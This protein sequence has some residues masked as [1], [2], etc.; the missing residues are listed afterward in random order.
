MRSLNEMFSMEEVDLMAAYEKAFDVPQ[1]E[2]ITDWWGDL[3]VYEFKLNVKP[4]QAEERLKKSLAA[5]NMSREEYAK[6]PYATHKALVE[7][8][9]ENTNP[10]F[11]LVVIF[12]KPVLFTCERLNRNLPIEGVNYYDIRHDDVFLQD[13]ILWHSLK[14]ALWLIIG[15]LLSAKKGLSR[16]K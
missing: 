2:R 9:L 7:K 15:E 16:E 11:D 8:M 4:E 5:I 3:A 12:D 13:R 1:A 10:K 14:T 6:N